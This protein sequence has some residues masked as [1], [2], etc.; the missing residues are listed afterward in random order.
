MQ[1]FKNHRPRPVHF[2]IFRRFALCHCRPDFLHSSH[3]GRILQRR[4]CH[5]P[6]GCH[7]DGGH[8]RS[9]I[10][11]GAGDGRRDARKGEC[12]GHSRAH[13]RFRGNADNN[14]FPARSPD[15][16]WQNSELHWCCP[17]ACRHHVFCGQYLVRLRDMPLQNRCRRSDLHIRAEMLRLRDCESWIWA[18][19]HYCQPPMRKR[20][21][22]ISD[23]SRFL[24]N[25]HP[26]ALQ[27]PNPAQAPILPSS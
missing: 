21:Y 26:S 9:G 17:A 12:L 7:A 5:A 16:L 3:A 18:N 15:D 6:S 22:V 27:L 10:C 25:G 4:N 24:S 19:V 8:R 20:M 1:G 13:G 14:S 23:F 2:A 11:R